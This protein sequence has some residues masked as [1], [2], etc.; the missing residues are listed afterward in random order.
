VS[1]SQA[2][3]VGIRNYEKKPAS[4]GKKTCELSKEK[5]Q[6]NPSGTLMMNRPIFL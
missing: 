6:Q 4:E 2:L 1:F 3:V 5:Y